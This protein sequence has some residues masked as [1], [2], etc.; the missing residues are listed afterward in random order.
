MSTLTSFKDGSLGGGPNMSAIRD[1]SLGGG[2][3]MSAFKDGSL[4]FVQNGSFRDGSLGR[5]QSGSFKDGS[6]GR[7]QSG[8]FKDGSLG[9]GCGMKG[10]GEDAPAA[11][12]TGRNPAVMLFSLLAVVGA[13][14]FFAAKK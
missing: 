7:T 13:V 14:A 8:S 12:S 4:G 1:G 5:T 2:S 10:L 3:N 6:L 11:A 9:C